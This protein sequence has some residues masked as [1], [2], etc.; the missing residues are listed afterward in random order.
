MRRSWAGARISARPAWRRGRRPPPEPLAN[1]CACQPDQPDAAGRPRRQSRARAR[2]SA[3]V[4]RHGPL[5]GVRASA[6]ATRRSPTREAQDSCT[7]GSAH[8]PA[9]LD[10]TSRPVGAGCAFRDVAGTAGDQRVGP[11]VRCATASHSSASYLQIVG[12][13]VRPPDLWCS[14][15]SR[16]AIRRRALNS[17][18]LT[19]PVLRPSTSRSRR[20]RAVRVAPASG[21]ARSRGSQLRIARRT[22]ARRS[23]I[24][25]ALVVRG[26]ACQLDVLV[27]HGPALAAGCRPNEV[28]RDPIE[29]VA[30]VRFALEGRWPVRRR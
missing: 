19:L 26:Q 27:A 28:R 29:I 20:G 23:G 30:A 9:A 21:A 15:R 25:R 3:D 16:A 5:P 12:L 11:V 4:P 10:V 13:T 6:R 18:S 7:R 22:S 17:S 14:P 1:P 8:P 2:P 24:G